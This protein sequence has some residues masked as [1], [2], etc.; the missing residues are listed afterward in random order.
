MCALLFGMMG[1][2]CVVFFLETHE[3]WITESK[4]LRLSK[5]ITA[6]PLVS[7]TTL[8]TPDSNLHRPAL[9]H[10]RLLSEDVGRLAEL[11]STDQVREVVDL[12]GLESGRTNE[13]LCPTSWGKEQAIM[14]DGQNYHKT[15]SGIIVEGPL[16]A[17]YTRHFIPHSAYW[18][19]FSKADQCQ[20]PVCWTALP[21]GQR[22]LTGQKCPRKSRFCVFHPC[23]CSTMVVRQQTLDE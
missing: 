13:E 14:N 5:Q 9:Q 16:P 21:A 7:E 8:T 12:V 11:V 22:G 3:S 17:V 23:R 6:W 15:T 2:W 4:N 10:W 18:E 19:N 1:Q 20:V